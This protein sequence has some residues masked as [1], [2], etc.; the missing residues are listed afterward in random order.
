L[1]KD[2][3]A[4]KDKKLKKNK[5]TKDSLA[6]FLNGTNEKIPNVK[7]FKIPEKGGSFVAYLLENMKDK[8]SDDAS[9]KDDDDEN[10]D[11]KK[12][13]HY[14]WWYEIFWMEKAQRMIM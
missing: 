6:V 14:S 3:K 1:Y 13:N 10:K 8:S 12:E 2:I 11:D 5:L 4:V 7:T 9:D